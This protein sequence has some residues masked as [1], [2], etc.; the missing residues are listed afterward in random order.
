MNK[1]IAKLF[2]S[3]LVIIF[4]IST[5][6]PAQSQNLIFITKWFDNKSAAFS[7]SF[8]DGLKSHFTNVRQILNQFNFKGTFYLLPPYLTETE[9]T[10]WRYGTWPMFQT[11]ASEGHEIGSHTLNHLYLTTLPVGDT[12]TQNSI[13]YEMYQSKKIIEQRITNQKCLT[14]AYPFA[15]HNSTV[16]SLA[17]MFYES[18]RAVGIDAND[19]QLTEDSFYSLKSYPVHF[20]LPRNSLDDDLDELYSFMDWTESAIYNNRWAI[21]MVHDVVPFSE[22][23]DLVSQGIYEPI[24][25]EWF[26]E[27]CSWLKNKSDSEKVW[28][29][30]I[31]DVIK[32]I[33][34]RQNSNIQ[35]ISVTDTVILFNISDNLDNEIYNFPLTCM[36]KVPDN[37]DAVYFNQNNRVDT[38]FTFQTDS[39]KFVQAWVL[40]DNGFVLLKSII[41]NSVEDKTNLPSDFVLKQNYPNP[42]NPTTKIRY[43]IP[44]V[45]TG[46]ALSTLKVYDILGNEIATLVNEE[47]PAGYYEVEFN[48]TEL[49]SGVYFYRLQSSTFT[50]TKKMILMR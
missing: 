3:V 24:S 14:L 43:S 33:R 11:L 27:Y 18:G 38:I 32:Y 17:K 37:W 40:P 12:S 4:L 26:T 50:Q 10:I 15:D 19:F 25:N 48:A 23:G 29:A 5:K 2:N 36:I 9:P 35:L 22:L 39:G 28:V 30:P 49:S 41:I 1:S 44:N 20:S 16:D 45:G 31:A 6:L 21:M 34:E 7:F 46:L 13:I 8:D 47:K 42:F